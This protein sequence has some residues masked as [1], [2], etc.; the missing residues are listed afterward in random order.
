MPPAGIG[1]H[2]EVGPIVS[3]TCE[4]GGFAGGETVERWWRQV[5]EQ[6]KDSEC[7][8]RVDSTSSLFGSFRKAIWTVSVKKEATEGQGSH[9]IPGQHL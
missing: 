4:G 7:N 3:S 6:I 1:T 2:H 9:R 8:R 5:V